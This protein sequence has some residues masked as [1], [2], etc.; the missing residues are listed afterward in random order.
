MLGLADT[1]SLSDRDLLEY[2]EGMRNLRDRFKKP[3][4]FVY[5][6]AE[7]FVLKHGTFFKPSGLPDGIRPMR[8]QQC[9]ENSFR[10]AQRTK[11][12]HYVEGFAIGIIPVAHAWIVDADGNAFDPTWAS[13]GDLGASYCGVELNLEEVKMSRR[14]GCLSLLEDWRRDFPALQCVDSIFAK[15]AWFKR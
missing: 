14:G 2:L 5:G 7:E 12:V 6:S 13:R 8:L 11:A 1:K 4:I 3:G 10:V 15:D 9:F